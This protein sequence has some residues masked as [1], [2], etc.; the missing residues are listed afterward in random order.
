MDYDGV[1]TMTTLGAERLERGDSRL[2]LQTAVRLRWFGVIGQLTTVVIV[3]FGLQFDL[4]FGLC[5]A[6]IALSAWLNV[7]LRIRYPAR[8]RLSSRF[9]TGLLAYD[10]A[11]LSGLLFLTGGIDNPFTFLLVVPVTVSAATLP[12]RNTILLG[13]LTAVSTVLLAF[14]HYP[15]P[16]HPGTTFGLPMMYKWGVLA[17]VGAGMVFLALYTLRLSNESTQMSAAL[18]ATEAIL[19]REQQLHA[20]D[21]LAAAAAHELG[22]PLS[23]ITLVA[24]ELGRDVPKGSPIADDLAL[25]QS[26]AVR[27]KEILQKLTR[28]PAERD[29]LHASLS[30]TQLIQEASEPY[31]KHKARV[32]VSAGPEADSGEAGRVEPFGERRPGVIYGLGNL[33]ENATEFARD[34][35]QIA[36]RW[37]QRDVII[38]I[39][40]DGPGFPIDLMDS[41][42]EPYVTTRSAKGGGGARYGHA[43]G[44]GLGFFIAKTLLERSGGEVTLENKQKPDR[45]AIVRV[46]WT[47]A[48]FEA[49]VAEAG[50]W[51]ARRNTVV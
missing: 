18:A 11:Q 48:A 42:G 25:L 44:L 37:S 51:P 12:P 34:Q 27:C 50:G 13:L 24:K 45:G 5:L 35:V 47:R 40:D 43:T 9:A 10:I 19:A 31:L 2:R 17:S 46:K 22:T 16:W 4:A 29:P 39:A 1:G 26:Q 28:S 8:H 38:T 20:I 21:G 41:L 7:F 23:T 49:G 6:M 36:A 33:I 32:A 15:L 14:Y 3:Y 30:I